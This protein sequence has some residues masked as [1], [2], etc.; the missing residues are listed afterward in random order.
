MPL[1]E[2]NLQDDGILYEYR[3]FQ[4]WLKDPLKSP[5]IN[6]ISIKATNVT[7]ENKDGSIAVGF[8]KPSA[9]HRPDKNFDGVQLH[10]DAF[11][12]WIFSIDKNSI[13]CDG[14]LICLAD[15]AP[16]VKWKYKAIPYDEPFKNKSKKKPCCIF[17]Y[18]LELLPNEEKIMTFKVPHYPI[19][20]G[21]KLYLKIISE[22]NWDEVIYN[23]E[24]DSY[25]IPVGLGFGQV[26]KQGNTVYNVFIEPQVSVADKGPGYPEWQIFMG[27]NLQF[28]GP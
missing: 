4:Y 26:I 27:L 9:D 6:F 3:I 18:D 21:K 17:Q 24:N 2:Y 13:F 14:K 22:Q 19:P 12:K 11:H 10:Q 20:E 7:N 16:S 23:F 15:N 5:L 25:S 1:V 8:V 28:L